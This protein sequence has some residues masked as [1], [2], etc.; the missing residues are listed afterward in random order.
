MVLQRI[1]CQNTIIV[2]FSNLSKIL[3]GA[4][5]TE[6]KLGHTVDADAAKFE[7]F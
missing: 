7:N 4:L 1:T 3:V 6:N 2:T 5:Q